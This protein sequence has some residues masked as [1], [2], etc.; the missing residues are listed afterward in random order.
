MRDISSNA[1]A[2]IQQDSNVEPVVIVKVYWNGLS[3]SPIA[4]CDAKY[5]TEGLIGR[6]VAMG[7]V[8]DIVD[9]TAA[10]S[11]TSLQITLDDSVGDIKQ[12]F[13]QTDIH[14]LYV[15]VL[16]WFTGVSLA[17]AF[18]LFE[19][20]ISTPIEWSEGERTLKFDVVSLIEDLEVGYSIEEANVPVVPAQL[21]GEVIPVIFGTVVGLKA[22]PINLTPSIILSNG[23]GL[24]DILQWKAELAAIAKSVQQAYNNSRAAW[25]SGVAEA[26][27]ASHYKSAF[28]DP[29]DIDE[30]GFTNDPAQADQHDQAAQDYFRQSSSYMEEYT[31]L[32]QELTL[33]NDEFQAQESIA[34]DNSRPSA[35]YLNGV[36]IFRNAAGAIVSDSDA[37]GG[38]MPFPVPIQYVNMPNGV[39]EY[40]FRGQV[41]NYVGDIVTTGGLTPELVSFTNIEILTD[42]KIKVGTV[43]YNFAL[44]KGAVFDEYNRVGQQPKFIWL[45]GGTEIKV[46]GFP[47]IFWL[48]YDIAALLNV[49]AHSKYGRRIVPTNLYQ[50]IPG[51]GV[52]PAQLVFPIPLEQFEGDWQSGTVEVDV[53][54]LASNAIDVMTFAIETFS[55]LEIDT[56]SFAAT[57]PTVFNCNFALLSRMNVVQFLKEVGYQNRCAVWMKS[58]RVFVKN[59]AYSYPSIATITDDDVEVNSLVISSTPTESIVTKYVAEWKYNLLEVDFNEVIL[60]YNMLLYGKVEQRYDF[61]CFNQ[62]E[63]VQQAAQFWMIRVSNSWK[64]VRFKV[65]LNHLQI[66]TFDTITL[67]FR[68]K[69]VTTDAVDVIVQKATFNSD[70]YSVEI[71]CWCPVRLGEMAPYDFAFPGTTQVIYPNQTD[72]N[73]QTGNPLDGISF[74]AIASNFPKQWSLVTRRNPRNLSSGSGTNDTPADVQ[75]VTALANN[76]VLAAFQPGARPAGGLAQHNNKQDRRI[77][78]ITT[79][80]STAAQAS[81]FFGRVVSQRTDDETGVIIVKCF[82]FLNG[83][84]KP[85]Q[86]QEI[87]VPDLLDGQLIP[88]NTGIIIQRT[89]FYIDDPTGQIDPD[90]NKPRQVLKT[91][92]WAQPPIWSPAIIPVGP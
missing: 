28:S 10:A 13:D 64:L 31:K 62:Y 44:P 46:F 4:Y 45:D 86:S 78:D 54:G 41:G 7:T 43:A 72:P 37:P 50:F 53:V 68:E 85:A 60:R 56:A 74:P 73:I 26:V 3:N 49:W 5:A 21:I 42:T 22:V 34:V 11:S 27:I 16:Q 51:A 84:F 80:T 29:G 75:I 65:N 87:Y 47:R 76:P 20:Q 91:E 39:P 77:V 66:E 23:F 48:G 14:K 8:E 17:D 6:L 88:A 12:I 55:T 52:V 71:E 19:G 33:R 82:M 89:V 61:F 59:L 83:L 81:T 67:Q 38:N 92:Y 25:A 24:I 70:D 2:M 90:T 58:K 63:Y 1:L 32:Q 35:E 79:P 57:R 69:L 18:T 15:E 9:I 40:S 30:F 36:I